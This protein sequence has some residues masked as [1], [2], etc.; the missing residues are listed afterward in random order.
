ML[1]EITE[2]QDNAVSLIEDRMDKQDIVVFRAPTGSGKTYMMA[3]YMNRVL[4]KRN[5]VVFL[6]SSLSSGGLAEQN[7]EKFV[8]YSETGLFKNIDPFLISTDDASEASIFIPEDRNVYVLPRDLYKEKSKLK[9]TGAFSRF[10]VNLTKGRGKQIWLIRDECHDATNKLDAENEYFSKIL[11]CSATPFGNGKRKMGVP[12]VEI[13]DAEAVQAK[14]IKEV[15]YHPESETIK[16]ALEEY[17]HI[18]REYQKELG[19]NPCLI[20]QVSNKG[21]VEEELD[22]LRHELDT[23]YSDLKWMYIL[24]KTGSG[25]ETNDKNL[26]KLPMSEWR[27]LAKRNT[28]SIDVIIFKLTIKEGWDI[29]RACMLYQIRDVKSE[30]LTEQVI[31][32]VRRNPKLVDFETLTPKQQALC[33]NAHVWGRHDLFGR[34]NRVVKAVVP[35]SSELT[36]KTTRLKTPLPKNVFDVRQCIE[37]SHG[38]RLTVKSIF[39]LY[40]EQNAANKDIRDLMNDYVKDYEDWFGFV[41]NLDAIKRE[42]NNGICNYRDSMY[43]NQTA[44]ILP[45]ES[46]YEEQEEFKL[47][48]IGDWLWQRDDGDDFTF[49]SDAELEFADILKDLARAEKLVK[50]IGSDERAQY[51]WAKN[52][53]PG[54]QIF[55]EYYLNG[56][57][58][59]Y[60]DFIM[61][62]KFD[63]VHI[64]EVKSVNKSARQQISEEEYEEKVRALIECYKFASEKTGQDFYIPIKDGSDWTIHHMHDGGHEVLYSIRELKKIIEK[65]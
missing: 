42:Y 59:S 34:P 37:S 9:Q 55:F 32:R 23:N 22:L 5:D 38:E 6:V 18:K 36:V 31:G 35:G 25:S 17:R 27:D 47:R 11:N 8:Q 14:L 28:S 57:H 39:T 7:Y 48:R 49:D 4:S 45:A 19:I 64:F 62:D 54:S 15:T 40:K 58:K 63:R 56:I 65:K 41:N 16:D 10:L 50:N 44:E 51:L 33:L 26:N 12:D 24:D 1:S 60:P 43:V 52:Y 46:W 53:L 13:T 2:L 61:K 29:P 30:T 3:D 21:K 20:I